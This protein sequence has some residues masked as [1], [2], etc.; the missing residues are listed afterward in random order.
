MSPTRKAVLTGVVSLAVVMAAVPAAFA[1][2]HGQ[3]ASP[4]CVRNQL[5]VRPNG[6]NGAAGTIRNAWVFTNLSKQT[7]RLV[8]YPGMQLYGKAGRPFPTIVK[9]T[10]PPG[11]ATVT[12]SP[13]G[14]GTFFSSYSD[15]PSG[16]AP[17]T[18]SRVAAITPPNAT[19]SLFIPAQLVPCRGI[20]NVSAVRAGVHRP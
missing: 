3:N 19:V 11:P 13:G 10:L 1:V 18:M 8:G 14:S 5:G 2:L 16:N 4:N 9:R 17:C 12:L 6:S 7:C 20:V 15:V